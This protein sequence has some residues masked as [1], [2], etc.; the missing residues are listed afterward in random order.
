MGNIYKHLSIKV[1][2]L[3]ISKLMYTFVA[4]VDKKS[5]T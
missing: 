1:A 3:G 2:V 4:L 5:C